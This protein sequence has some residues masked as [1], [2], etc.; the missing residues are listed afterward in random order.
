MTIVLVDDSAAL[1]ERIKTMLSELPGVVITGEAA[2][3]GEAIE[4][5][6]ARKP[7]VVI[8]DIHMPGGSGVDV[9]R[10]VKRE[11]P[12]TVVM[13]LTNYASPQYRNVCFRAGADHFFDKFAEHDRL[14]A[15]VGKLSQRLL[16]GQP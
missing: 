10:A 12:A 13:M 6:Q 7:D 3:V 8:L 4:V 14:M 5:I 15:T 1:R 16:S 9:L 2:D 11:R